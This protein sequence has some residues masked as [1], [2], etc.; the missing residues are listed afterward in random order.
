MD[1]TINN[2]I[3]HQT[4]FK[5]GSQSQKQG[6]EN[7]I[8]RKGEAAKLV[9]ATFGTGIGF[10]AKA[11]FDLLDGDFI[12]DTFIES[13]EKIANKNFKN[14]KG[15]KKVIVKIGAI[16][17][18]AGLFVG[19][20]ASLYTILSAPKISYESKVKTFEKTKEFD[21]Y[22]KTNEIE[23]NLYE[24][25]NNKAKEASKEEKEELKNQ[26]LLLKKAK[27]NTPDIQ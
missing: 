7:P 13:G 21:A 14:T 8:T 26:Y 15:P 4:A 5:N 27:N 3:N 22:I 1:L 11:L 24:Q 10:G 23:K 18:L 20:L 12:V 16:L 17:G 2:R 19:G 25:I 6:S 9:L